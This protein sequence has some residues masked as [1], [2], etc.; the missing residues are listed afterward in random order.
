MSCVIIIPIYKKELAKNEQFSLLRCFDVLKSYQIIFVTH[1]GLHLDNYYECLNNIK[2]NVEYFDKSY[3]TSIQGYNKLMLSKDFYHRFLRYDYML[4]YQLDCYVFEDKLNYWCSLNYD[5]IGA[6]W[7]YEEYFSFSFIKRLRIYV[8]NVF[9]ISHSFKKL[10]RNNLYLNVGNGGFSLRR[11][12][13]FYQH[14]LTNNLYT[15]FY[16]NDGESLY[17]EDVYWSLFANGIKKPKYKT[18]V[19]FALD[20]GAG[21]GLVMNGNKLPFGC[22]AWHRNLEFW[23]PFI[24]AEKK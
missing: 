6:P 7:L 12:S 10:S 2:F 15:Q 16:G 18:A 21:R 17:N 8:N 23:S 20:P 1:E 22:H 9:N 5:Y 13:V 4:I 11:V 3:F 19:G 14:L 24:F